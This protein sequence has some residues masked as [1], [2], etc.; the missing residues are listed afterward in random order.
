[1]RHSL[2]NDPAPDADAAHQSPVAMNLTA[3]LST[4]DS[5]IAGSESFFVRF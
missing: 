5:D 2:L 1:M 4:K 3:P